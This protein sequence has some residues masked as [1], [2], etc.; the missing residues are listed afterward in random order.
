MA[1]A[2]SLAGQVKG[3]DSGSLEGGECAV[4]RRAGRIIGL[5]WPSS[6]DMYIRVVVKINYLWL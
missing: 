5:E 4:P 3:G 2:K 6:T 1:V